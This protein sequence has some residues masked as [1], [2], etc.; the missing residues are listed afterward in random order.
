MTDKLPKGILCAADDTV[1]AAHDGDNGRV[2]DGYG[3][4]HVCRDPDVVWSKVMG[5]RSR[6]GWRQEAQFISDL[7]MPGR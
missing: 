1:E 6:P 3:V 5:L 4:Q 2:V 7:R